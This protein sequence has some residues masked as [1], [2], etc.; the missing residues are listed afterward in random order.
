MVA[1]VSR[2]KMS[3]SCD[4]ARPSAA[5]AQA[6]LVENFSAGNGIILARVMLREPNFRSSQHY[7]TYFDVHHKYFIWHL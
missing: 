2:R 4:H 5:Q 6:Q 7:G 3:Q 1:M